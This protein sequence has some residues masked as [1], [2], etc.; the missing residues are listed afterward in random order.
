MIFM[1]NFNFPSAGSRKQALLTLLFVF[2]LIGTAAHAAGER[3]IH[4]PIAVAR[5]GM[6]I[7]IR[8]G[9]ESESSA[10]ESRVYYRLPGQAA[11]RYEE[12]MITQSG[13]TGAI[14]AESVTLEGLEYYLWVQFEN[15]A[16]VSYPEDAPESAPPLM[17]SVNYPRVAKGRI[18]E[19]AIIL[20]PKPG[21][22]IEDKKPLIAVSFI[23]ALNADDLNLLH[24]ELD[25]RDLTNTADVS[26][27]LL[28][29][30][31][32]K[33]VPG[34]HVVNIFKMIDG[35]RQNLAAYHF[36]VEGEVSK[37]AA[38]TQI[39]G[40]VKGG[41]THEDV[42][43]NIRNIT[44]LNSKLYGNLGEA[45]W[46]TRVYVSNLERGNLQPQN[47]FTVGVEYR[48]LTVKAGDTNPR[49]SEFTLYGVRSRG[50][51]INVRSAYMNFDA[52]YGDLR[53]PIEG[54]WLPDTT[55]I[56]DDISGDTLETIIEP[57]VDNA[58]TYQRFL[59]GIRPGINITKNAT[60]SFNITKVKDE[61]NSIDYGV[62]PK[63]N[64]T[65]G[66]D[67]KV[68]SNNR[69]VE[70]TSETAFSLYN[71]DISPGAMKD[72]KD[73][74]NI[75]VINQ[76]FQP[77]PNDSSILEE[78]ISTSDLL[79]ELAEELV[80]S[81][82]AHRT[83]LKL[84]YYNNELKIGYKTVGSAYKSLSSPTVLTDVQ[85][86]SIFDRIRLMKKRIYLTLGYEKYANNV[87]GRNATT[88]DRNII[89]ASVSYYS[90]PKYP[91]FGF[92]VRQYNRSN[93]GE[94]IETDDFRID[95]RIDHNSAS[96]HFRVDQA[97]DFA[98]LSHHASLFFTAD[99]GRDKIF[100]ELDTDRN[101]IILNL[102]SR[103]LKLIDTKFAI[104]SES[105]ESFE[106]KNA[107]DYLNV[108]ASAR[109][110]AWQNK[111]WV[112][113]GITHS[114]STGS[115]KELNPEPESSPELVS[116]TNHIDFSRL[117]FSLGTEF[118]WIDQHF[119]DFSAYYYAQTDNG[120][121]E[122]YDGH[123]VGNDDSL[124]GKDNFVARLT[125]SYR[126]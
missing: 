88:L 98:K 58:G 94:L 52:V 6:D 77:L 87:N 51:E 45:K 18:Q 25:G 34:R 15:N 61:E 73:F 99:Q 121:L 55:Y 41:Y 49:F 8:A 66:F 29:V 48:G 86:F 63:D 3:I 82:M 83:S 116:K 89:N 119:V 109:Y 60:L 33:L 110:M 114:K 27:E 24:V 43:N 53:R 38:V 68:V 107:V 37:T 23:P 5:P 47:R 80:A 30:F 90:D 78:G 123:T 122:Y 85:G 44:F 57:A 56:L 102:D 69:R 111:L 79:S 124:S 39:H 7:D 113:G 12:L 22:M 91:N 125:Y 97:F 11:F 32:P 108:S 103:Y 92:G 28:T 10:L 2:L 120:T 59:L 93:D 36:F 64:V 26:S 101:G 54:S 9:I 16:L 115:D 71:D 81:A 62:R 105:Q 13:M 118:R 76:N 104:N 67:L 14:P 70:F 19:Q 35:E 117:Q 126:F 74:E 1:N 72:A 46:N 17:V 50:A 42:S 96:Y 31:A 75:L 21:E 65:A 4:T 106:G 40:N 84:S 95:S 112:S 20:S 100:P